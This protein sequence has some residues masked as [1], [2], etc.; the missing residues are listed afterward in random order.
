MNLYEF[1]VLSLVINEVSP[2]VVKSFLTQFLSIQT[3]LQ[4][5][6]SCAKSLAGLISYS[7]W[8]RKRERTTLYI[9]AQ[10]WPDSILSILSTERERERE[11]E[12]Q[13]SPPSIGVAKLLLQLRPGHTDYE[14]RISVFTDKHSLPN[15]DIIQLPFL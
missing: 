2:S 12:R 3:L 5:F 8:E 13:S 1:I 7:Q 6:T 4:L 11:R 9:L 15:T 14:Y 10:F